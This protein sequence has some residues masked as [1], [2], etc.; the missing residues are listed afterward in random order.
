MN[1]ETLHPYNALIAQIKDIQEQRQMAQA[2]VSRESGVPSGT[3]SQFLTGKYKG[4]NE[5]VAAQLRRW[6]ETNTA[7]HQLRQKLRSA[8]DFVLLP[9]CKGWL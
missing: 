2:Q 5:K 8:P 7:R 4:D 6:V 3:L 9:S 1:N